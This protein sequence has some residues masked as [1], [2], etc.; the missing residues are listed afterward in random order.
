MSRK[1]SPG[2]RVA[3]PLA[4]PPQRNTL[5]ASATIL[6]ED[7]PLSRVIVMQPRDWQR[8]VWNFYHALGELQFGIGVWLANSVSRVRLI[9]A[10][11]VPGGDEPTPIK[12]GPY[13]DLVQS[14]CGGLGGQS[15]MLKKVAVHLSIPGDSYIVG[16]DESGMGVVDNFHWR[17]YSS[18]EIRQVSKKPIRYQVQ[19]YQGLWR[20]LA[21]ESLVVRV[22]YPD[23][24]LSWMAASPAQAAL[25][26]MR[27]V[28]FY[29]R[30]IVAILLSRL[31]LNGLLLIPSEATMPAKAQ[32]KDAADPFIAELI[33][34][35]T[36]SIANPGSASAAVP[37]PLRV[38]ADMIDKVK[39]LTFATPI[40]EKIQ[41]HRSQALGRLAV[42]LNMPSEVLSGMRDMNHWGQWQM[43]ESGIKTYISPLVEVIV[44]GLL[45]GYLK[46]MAMAAGLD[47][48]GPNGG[49][50]VMWYDVSELVKQPDRVKETE[51]LYDRGEAGG[52]ALRREAGI[53]ES[54]KPDM[55]ELKTM[56][57]QKIAL[58][59]GPDA[60]FALSKLTGDDSLVPPAPPAP[61]VG[62]PGSTSPPQNTDQAPSGTEPTATPGSDQKGPPD[63]RPVAPP[64]TS[65]RS[66]VVTADD[67]LVSPNGK[68]V[69]RV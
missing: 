69:E 34:V 24:E 17:V 41:E 35:A 64:K 22:W 33:D 2:A 9:A 27:E 39:H 40:E 65:V 11:L 16:E 37:I 25:S 23:D 57:L 44:Y 10:E 67:W 59:A 29:N 55:E 56:I 3:R 28:D 62:Q 46:P 58:G 43:E 51:E 48:I 32:F 1:R 53:E 66:D 14:F 30:Y 50:V 8:E 26:I 31:A 47:M 54:D 5:V 38:P 18:S 6:D 45:V 42:A 21:D 63:T 36:K 49:Q 7:N 13:A 15:A 19:E 61:G 4:S 52:E 68:S 12:E 20:T 60:L